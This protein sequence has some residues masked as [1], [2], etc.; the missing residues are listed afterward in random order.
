MATT[1]N[2]TFDSKR[3]EEFC[4]DNHVLW[5]SFFGSVLEDHFRE[6]SDVDVLIEFKEGHTPG[7]FKLT[8]LQRELSDIL[9]GREVDLRT[10]HE[11]SRYFR[12]DVLAKA[13]PQY[14]AQEG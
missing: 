10:P 5:L 1:Q 12:E 11:L 6:D 13:V 4:R 9:A 3:L 8:R 2:I 7:L 14:Q